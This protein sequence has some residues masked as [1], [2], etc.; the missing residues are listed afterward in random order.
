MTEKFITTPQGEEARVR[1]RH[2]RKD[3]TRIPVG[4]MTTIQPQGSEN[5]FVGFS[6]C[7]NK[8]FFTK[9]RG[10]EVSLVRAQTTMERGKEGVLYGAISRENVVELINILRTEKKLTSANGYKKFIEK[11]LK[12]AKNYK[13]E[14][15]NEVQEIEN[16]KFI[17]N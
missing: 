13:K 2:F 11:Y 3:K 4:T 15:E 17:A 5:V 1:F 16:R 12:Q 10:R 8:D 6:F 14:I 9:R 7:S